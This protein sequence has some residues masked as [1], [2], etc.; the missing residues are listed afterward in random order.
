MLM[1]G[2]YRN[3]NDTL[4]AKIESQYN[5][6]FSYLRDLRGQKKGP[7]QRKN[8]I[9]N[10][11]SKANLDSNADTLASLNSDPV[12]DEIQTALE[13]EE[14]SNYGLNMNDVKTLY[15]N[16]FGQPNEKMKEK[17]NDLFAALRS[18]NFIN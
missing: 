8:I 9:S 10:S 4:P 15:F 14:G 16:Y 12:K 18:V 13:S 17:V 11:E 6:I 5:Q 7:Q 1:R 3:N 2:I